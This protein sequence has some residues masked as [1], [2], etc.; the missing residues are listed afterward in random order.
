M[1]T[2]QVVH[3]CA[4]RRVVQDGGGEEP[5]VVHSPGNVHGSRQGYG[6]PCK[7]ST[8]EGTVSVLHLELGGDPTAHISQL[9][10]KQLLLLPAWDGH[11]LITESVDHGLIRPGNN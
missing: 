2:V 10:L 3:L 1:Q 9:P 7:K 4:F 8:A 11:C 5:E 6:F